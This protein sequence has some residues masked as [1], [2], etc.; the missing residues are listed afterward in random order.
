L[1][2]SK[3]QNNM[4][5]ATVIAQRSHDAETKVGAILVNNTSGAIVATG[6]NGFVRGANDSILPTTRPDKYEYILHAEQNLI[7]NCARHGISM[8]NCSLVC[9]LSPCKLCMRMLLN[10]GITKVIAKDLY[11]DFDDI[12]KMQDVKVTATQ[13]SDGFWHIAYQVGHK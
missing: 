9:T 11:K 7:A 3:N 2:P 8:A 5:A 10:C 4:D 6:Y 12:L 1:R 13:E